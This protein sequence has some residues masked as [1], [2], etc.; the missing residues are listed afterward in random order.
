MAPKGTNSFSFSQ[1]V[2]E[3]F[4]IKINGNKTTGYGWFL[5]N[6]REVKDMIIP[7]NMNVHESTNDYQSESDLSRLGSP[8]YYLFKF[9]GIKSGTHPK[10][11]FIQKRPWEAEILSNLEVKIKLL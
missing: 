10:L 7:L 5:L 11:K 9:K 3:N 4:T 6:R 1:K 8:G 2:G